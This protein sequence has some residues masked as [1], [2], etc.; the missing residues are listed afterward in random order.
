MKFIEMTTA[1]E[2][3]AKGVDGIALIRSLLDEQQDLTA[4]ERFAKKHESDAG[5]AQSK[6]Y[7]DL[8]PL[9]EPGEGQQYAFEVDL[10]ACTGCKAC[11]TACHNLNGLDDTEAWRD[12]GMLHGGTAEEPV[13]QTVTTA[14]HH[15]LEPACQTG[16]PVNAYE[17]DPKTGIV[18]HLDDQCIGCQYCILKCPYD[19]PKYNK[20]KGIV[21]KCDMCSDRLSEGEAPACVQ[22]C[23]NQAIAITIVN[24]DAVVEDSEASAFLPGAPDPGYTLPTTHYKTDRV[25]PRNMLPADHY[26]VRKEHAHMPLVIMLVLTQMSVGAFW[27]E[28]ML[29]SVVGGE[30]LDPIRP[31]HALSALGLGLLALVGRQVSDQTARVTSG[32]SH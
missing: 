20:E 5:P 14:C 32:E 19:V 31:F 10:D 11:V 23:P 21:R 18:K 12:V 28:Q 8:I 30:T 13:L 27:V 9:S 7:R 25:L 22:A 16:C 4:V 6:F 1:G 29:R 2:P 24:R 26:E 3:A 15:C 17:K